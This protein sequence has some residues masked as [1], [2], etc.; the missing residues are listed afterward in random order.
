MQWNRALCTSVLLGW[1]G[2]FPRERSSR[3]GNSVETPRRKYFA[4]IRTRLTRRFGNV[5][6]GKGL[7][8]G[9]HAAAN[10][11]TLRF[12]LQNSFRRSENERPDTK[13]RSLLRA[14]YPAVLS[15]NGLGRFVE[16]LLFTFREISLVPLSLVSWTYSRITL[17]QRGRCFYAQDFACWRCPARS[18]A[19]MITLFAFNY[20]WELFD[21]RANFSCLSSRIKYFFFILRNVY[22]LF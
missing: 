4:R 8:L 9:A 14:R 20:V 22:L 12:R 16:S 13:S 6:E 10:L 1:N 7:R 21:S 11:T 17:C 19:V 3:Q 2:C 5:P 15:E 18:L